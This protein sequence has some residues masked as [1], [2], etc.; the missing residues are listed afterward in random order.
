MKLRHGFL[1]MI[2][3]CA[4]L[5]A[6]AQ[7]ARSNELQEGRYVVAMQY[8]RGTHNMRIPGMILDSYR[9]IVWTCQNLQDEKPLWVKTDLGQNGS[10]P[11]TK[12]KYIVRMMEWQDNDLRVPAMVVDTEDGKVWNCPNIVDGKA[13]WIQKN[14]QDDVTP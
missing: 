3:A 5:S 8:G 7:T 11:M 14:L 6:R 2:L 10:K 9:G 12:K 13:V 4:C 1:A